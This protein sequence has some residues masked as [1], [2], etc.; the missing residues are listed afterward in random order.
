MISVLCVDRL[1]NYFKLA[2]PGLELWTKE[3]DAYNFFGD[4]PV[5]THPPCQQWSK[6]RTMA[7][8]DAK[9]KGLAWR[10]LDFVTRN[11]GVLEHPAY[12]T[13]FAEAGIKPTIAIDQSWFGFP[14]RKVTWLYF[15]KC[16]PLQHPISFDLARTNVE[17]MTS[18]MRSRMPE[19]F[20]SWLVRSVRLTLD[21]G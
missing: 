7:K 19:A 3:R 1:S 21:R 11:G 6:L 18:T 17:G 15:H 13:F 5:I 8:P 9:E 2:D 4:N 16:S 10:C 12:S 20:C 14:A